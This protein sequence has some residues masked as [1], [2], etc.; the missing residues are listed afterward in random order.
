MSR[1]TKHSSSSRIR[2]ALALAATLC[3]AM[4]LAAC[5]GSD[6]GGGDSAK[7]PTTGRLHVLVVEPFSGNWYPY[8]QTAGVERRIN[9]LLFDRLIEVAPDQ[10]FAPGLATSWRQVDD[11]TWEF[12]LRDGVRFQ[13]GA[14]FTAQDVKASIE[15]ASGKTGEQ[16]VISALWGVPQT[17]DVVDDSTVRIHG[18]TPLGPMLS[19]LATTDILSAAD[20][21]AGMRVMSRKPNGTGPFSLA[22]DGITKKT[23]EANPRYWRGPAQL[24]ST[25]WE[26]IQDPQSR[27][28]ALEAGQADLIERVDPDQA[29]R[30]ATRPGLKVQSI[31]SAE[32]ELLLFRGNRGVFAG[33]PA[34]RRAAASAIDRRAIAAL[35]GGKTTTADSHLA[36]A[37]F[38]YAAQEPAYTADL[39]KAREELAASGVKAPVP[40]ELVAP[41]GVFPKVQDVAQI[42]AQSLDRA[43]FKTKVTMLELGAYFDALGKGQGDLMIAGWNSAA[44]DPQ[45]ALGSMYNPRGAG[46]LWGVNDPRLASMLAEGVATSDESARAQIYGDVQAHMWETVPSLP[47]F[48]REVAVAEAERVQGLTLM[49]T[50][51]IDY[52]SIR[53]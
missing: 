22:D 8:T 37:N 33:N 34:L 32:I 12:K 14:P 45:L 2:R 50:P 53:A 28:N 38:F 25:T 27:I 21:K 39:A 10:R 42:I 48:Y 6:S 41:I 43:G 18:E 40:V 23:L 24:R 51:Q 16:S 11:K 19:L 17:V 3:A 15:L 20:V 26:F 1:M 13:N 4:L 29:E 31:V 47:L 36:P 44:P 46:G 7:V 49:P 9:Q 30:L 52:W 5:G 35:I